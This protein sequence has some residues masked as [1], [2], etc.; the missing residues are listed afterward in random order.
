MKAMFNK[1]CLGVK[2][3]GVNDRLRDQKSRCSLG[4]KRGCSQES[5]HS[6]H[7]ITREKEMKIAELL[8]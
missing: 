2:H 6:W 5:K 1:H 3:R 8:S 4:E 7:L